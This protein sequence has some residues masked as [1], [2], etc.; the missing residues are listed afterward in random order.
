MKRQYWILLGFVISSLILRI[1][2]LIFIEN[3]GL[4]DQNHYYNL[5]TRLLNGD[6]FTI[7]YVWHYSH[8]PASIEH[9]IDHWM[10]VA[11]IAAAIGMFIFGEGAQSALFLFIIMGS[12]L[13]VV[14]YS[15]AKQYDLS[16]NLALMASAFAISIPDFVWNSL[17]TD[18]TII[19]MLLI[20]AS[21]IAFIHAIKHQRWWSYIICGVLGGIAYLTRNDS[22]LILPLVVSCAV[23][24][25]IWGK[26]YT[27]R[28]QLWR[29]IVIPIAF[30]ITIAPWL[31]RNYQTLDMLG[32]PETSRMFF[33]VDAKDHY[34]YNMS[35]TLES[36]LERRTISE[37]INKRLFEFFA[38]IKQII[39]SLDGVLPLLMAIGL[40]SLLWQRNRQSWLTALPVVLWILGILIA[41]PFLL[42]LK[43]QSG[44]FE[45]AYLTI[46]PMMLPFAAFA[47]DRLFKNNL[48]RVIAVL[49]TVLLMAANSFD[50]VRSET[51]RANQFYANMQRLTDIIMTLD[52][53]TGDDEVRV[54]SQDPFPMSYFGI[55][56]VMTPLTT[57]REDVLA[58]TDRY[59]ID[60]LIMPAARPALDALY[61]QGE[62]D[63]RFTFM[64]SMRDE[65][66]ILYE[67]YAIT[68][69]VASDD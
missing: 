51:Q 12:L 5:G 40:L 8:L 67:I 55:K 27:N 54:M 43:S 24:Y 18:T 25:L 13:P 68:N 31:V 22:I 17:R 50:V 14:V 33:M 42:P 56:S 16:D 15:A 34:A 36:M 37:H 62:I 29:L 47:I 2:L 52:D 58:L 46:V 4:N 45:K 35:L 44:S 10:P 38:A 11:G 21:I 59:D 28:R 30:A 32:S 57:T 39:I 41:Y 49:V 61:Q 53:R 66:R 23:V 20:P 26:A 19:N 9:P 7:D 1:A 60:Y 63:E 3:P 69:E 48:W 64:T 6:G 65:T